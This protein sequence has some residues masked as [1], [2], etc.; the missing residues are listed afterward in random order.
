V[1]NIRRIEGEEDMSIVS[2]EMMAYGR[3]M[4]GEY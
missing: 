1:I 4:R 3:G 2:I